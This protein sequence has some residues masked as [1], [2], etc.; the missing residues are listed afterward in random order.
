MLFLS[1]VWIL[2]LAAPIHYSS[3]GEQVMKCYI[4]PNPTWFDILNINAMIGIRFQMS[5]C[6]YVLH[7][8]RAFIEQVNHFLIALALYKG[9]QIIQLY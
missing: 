6:V 5:N 7:E 2:I 3:I 8:G 1:A 4:S 9:L